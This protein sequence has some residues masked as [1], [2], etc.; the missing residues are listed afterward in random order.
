V[1][2]DERTGPSDPDDPD[3]PAGDAPA[4][5]ASGGDGAPAPVGDGAPAPVW[6]GAPV[7]R[8]RPRRADTGASPRA[9]RRRG[10]ARSTPTAP[11]PPPSSLAAPTAGEAADGTERRSR[12]SR[13]SQRTEMRTQRRQERWAQRRRV[14]PWTALLVVLVVALAGGAALLATGALDGAREFVAG[15]PTEDDAAALP[16]DLQPV[17]TVISVAAGPDGPLPSSIALLAVDRERGQGTVL[18][19]PPSTV[20]HV[21][22]HG[23][24][25]LRDAF[26]L[27]GGPLVGRSVDD[28]L[29][30]RS[31]ATVTVTAEGWADLLDRAGGAEA[32]LDDPVTDADGEVLVDA[33]SGRL[34]GRELAALL[35][36]RADGERELDQLPRVRD[37]LLA[38]VGQAGDDPEA[39]AEAFAGGAPEL[40][41]TPTPRADDGADEV[42]DPEVVPPD[43]DL[44]RAVLAELAATR[45]EGGLE[46][47]ALEVS[48]LTGSAEEAYRP[49]GASVQAFVGDRLAASRFDTGVAGGR[50]LQVLDGN[51]LPDVHERVAAILQPAG[52]RVL[53]TANADRSDHP[54]TRILLHDD[55]PGTLAAAEDVRSRLG[56]GRI[57]RAGTPQSVVDLTILVGRD[58]PVGGAE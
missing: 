50:S 35:T 53:L 42:P 11:A 10:R 21:P 41:V 7:P 31:D 17:V 22:G 27:G 51:G 30:I 34:D 45:G 48:A 49:D 47:E 16:G 9:R 18:L 15:G 2:E 12:A 43:A 1:S 13:V 6:D 36:F 55:D 44:V 26:E 4:G 23:A 32:S 5:D 54:E 33:G 14:L 40:E 3:T 19:V 28:L 58:F 25:R 39:F 20:T 29:G 56:V 52:Y 8:Q 37:G 46:V 38:I 57:E 24:L